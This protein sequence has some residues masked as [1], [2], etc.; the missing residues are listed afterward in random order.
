MNGGAYESMM[1]C[2]S[3]AADFLLLWKLLVLLDNWRA[4]D[5]SDDWA[6]PDYVR[7]CQTSDATRAAD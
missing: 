7:S 1:A 5:H 6:Q 3:T 4:P 2:L